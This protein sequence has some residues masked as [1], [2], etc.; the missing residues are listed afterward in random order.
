MNVVY[1]EMHHNTVNGMHLL[2][3]IRV[4]Q[5]VSYERARVLKNRAQNTDAQ[6]SE[7]SR[8]G[9]DVMM[10]NPQAGAIKT[11]FVIVFEG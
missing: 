8:I 11:T 9:R 6:F 4:A 5:D 3:R 2:A 1:M 10:L 7:L